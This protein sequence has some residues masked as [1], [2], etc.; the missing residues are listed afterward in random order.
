MLCT[1][2]NAVASADVMVRYLLGQARLIKEGHPH[3]QKLIVFA[4]DCM[5]PSPAVKDGVAA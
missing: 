3:V 1:S 4:I 2:R 5:P